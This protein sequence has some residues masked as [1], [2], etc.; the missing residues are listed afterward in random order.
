MATPG[1][2]TGPLP[3]VVGVT[4]HRDLAEADLP[5]LT[6]AVEKAFADLRDALP[7]CPL[8]VL[9]ALAEG[10]DRLA[11][12]VALKQG[13]LLLAVLPM[14][15]EE[16]EK[17]F[18]TAASVG[19]FRRLLAASASVVTVEGHGQIPGEPRSASYARAGVFIVRHCQVLLALWD[20][21][22]AEARGGT[23]Q[24]VRFKLRGA[25]PLSDLLGQ[26]L[27]VPETGPV[28]HLV[29]PRKRG[30]PVR[31][32]PFDLLKLFP[33]TPAGR[34]ES[35]ED[36][37]NG[38]DLIARFNRDA[39]KHGVEAGA[40]AKPFSPIPESLPLDVQARL[41]NLDAYHALAGGLATRFQRRTQ[42]TR[43]G[44]AVLGLLALAAHQFHI[45]GWWPHSF[46]L[47]AFVAC[48]A[49]AY[50]WYWFTIRRR[51]Y[52]NL[53][54][55]YRAL[56]EAMRVQYFWL[57][58]GIQESV[59]DHYLRKHRGEM[60]WIRAAISNWSLG[61][62]PTPAPPGPGGQ[63][64]LDLVLK[65]WVR[66]QLNYFTSRLGPQERQHHALESWMRAL[67]VVS[68]LGFITITVLG[69]GAHGGPPFL[70]AW[71][72]VVVMGA[73]T[74]GTGYAV[75]RAWSHGQPAADLSV[76]LANGAAH[77]PHRPW[78]LIFAMAGY[79]ALTALALYLT[80]KADDAHVPA[81]I[82]DAIA[83]A[84]I[85]AAAAATIVHFYAERLGFADHLRL[86][87]R[88]RD[89]YARADSLLSGMIADGRQR[90]AREV[91]LELGQ[92][93]LAENADWLLLHRGRPVNVP[94]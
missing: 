23:S 30:S 59:R 26:S 46:W 41:H 58:A 69:A 86:Y 64:V 15:R 77:H 19:E 91:L 40:G 48:L 6:A 54:Q 16:Y 94:H 9:S 38:F 24:V 70:H 31:G 34:P 8:V 1:D 36:L 3:L 68:V 12:D 18:D 55:D 20:G 61:V 66:D 52:Q 7:H 44:A 93:A 4:G 71:G 17:D 83:T 49:I 57:L 39:L 53:Y 14:P 35:A 33:P 73:A 11:A 75:V 80:W 45:R 5:A 47:A 13:A 10:A 25:P 79:A 87:T 21:D 89:I 2:Q 51:N 85:L 32:K 78:L 62:P 92:E 28:Y 65:H 72:V 63:G 56:A 81:R 60:R 74:L 84:G 22:P 29:T 82:G 88:M 76:G 43:R 27:D 37:G 67:I 90:E 50:G 42:W